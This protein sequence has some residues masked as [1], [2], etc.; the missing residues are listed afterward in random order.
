MIEKIEHDVVEGPE[1]N[2]ELSDDA[3]DRSASLICGGCSHWPHPE[4]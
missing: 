3:L 2:E 4:D 1:F